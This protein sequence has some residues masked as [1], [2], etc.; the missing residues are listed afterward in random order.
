MLTTIVLLYSVIVSWN[1]VTKV[2]PEEKQVNTPG[3]AMAACV[4]G[5]STCV[6]SEKLGIRKSSATGPLICF[7]QSWGDIELTQCNIYL[8]VDFSNTLLSRSLRRL[9]HNSWTWESFVYVRFLYAWLS[10]FQVDQIHS[11]GYSISI[12]YLKGFQTLTYIETPGALDKYRF[13]GLTPDT[14]IK[15]VWSGGQESAS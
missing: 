6:K 10:G 1:F 7:L 15:Q 8:W 4:K 9:Q 5:E 2:T 12:F 3:V 14:L 13:Q 11:F